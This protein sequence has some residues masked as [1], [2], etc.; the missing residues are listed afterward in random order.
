[1]VRSLAEQP[2]SCYVL[3]FQDITEYL[4]FLP[5]QYC[6]SMFDCG[7]HTT[8]SVCEQ[9]QKKDTGFNLPDDRWNRLSIRARD[10][11]GC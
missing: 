4:R 11:A 1:M 7:K 10:T 9:C 6:F 5:E 8:S 2:I 3:R